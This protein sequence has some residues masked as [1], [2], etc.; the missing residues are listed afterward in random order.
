MVERVFTFCFEDLL[1][2]EVCVHEHTETQRNLKV[3]YQIEGKI[4]SLLV[5][6][7]LQVH[8]LIK[9]GNTYLYRLF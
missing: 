9:K 3:A 4:L 6:E 1:N 8:I 7:N 2:F 5:T